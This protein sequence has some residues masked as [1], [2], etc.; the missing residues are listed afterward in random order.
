MPGCAWPNSVHAWNYIFNTV[1]GDQWTNWVWIKSIKLKLEIQIK[2]ALF[3]I[4][5]R[6]SIKFHFTM[7]CTKFELAQYLFA[8]LFLRE[9]LNSYFQREMSK[10][11]LDYIIDWSKSYSPSIGTKLSFTLVQESLD[12]TTIH[13]QWKNRQIWIF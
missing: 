2:V 12:L 7:Q 3:I 13:Q 10:R 11:D 6:L 4:L 5:L 1:S 8:F 9:V